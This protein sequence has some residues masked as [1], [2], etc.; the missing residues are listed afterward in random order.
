VTIIITV[1]TVI[2]II[3]IIIIVIS[4]SRWEV[5]SVVMTEKRDKESSV[6]YIKTE[7]HYNQ[8]RQQPELQ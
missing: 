5:W 7:A 2:I 8:S 6:A 1:I 4:I 3:I